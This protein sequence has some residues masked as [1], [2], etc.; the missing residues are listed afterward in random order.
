MQ[1]F[2][3]SENEK[4]NN[5]SY[6][7]LLFIYMCVCRI[8]FECREE[9]KISGKLLLSRIQEAGRALGVQNSGCRRTHL[10][11]SLSLHILFSRPRWKIASIARERV[12]HFIVKGLFIFASL[13]TLLTQSVASSLF[14]LY[15]DR[16]FPYKQG[17]TY[18]ISYMEFSF[19]TLFSIWNNFKHISFFSLAHI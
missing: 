19:K 10:Y 12:T 18:I 16:H 6:M 7:F 2:K 13:F 9:I 14:I 8:N 4:C 17:K 1:P 3:N 11:S 15:S 5:F